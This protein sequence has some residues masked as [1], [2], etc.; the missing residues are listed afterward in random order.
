MKPGTLVMV[1]AY[2]DYRAAL[3]RHLYVI[4][5]ADTGPEEAWIVRP[6][7]RSGQHIADKRCLSAELTPIAAFGLRI[8]LIDRERD[9]LVLE[10]ANGAAVA[11]RR[12]DGA[13]WR[14]G[15][16]FESGMSTPVDA[17]ALPFIADPQPEAT[18]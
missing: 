10:R 18:V 14:W 12:R 9:H 3:A 11:A 13:M 4:T 16:P 5:V 8:A 15:T 6:L 17:E 7:Y 1:Q 2:G